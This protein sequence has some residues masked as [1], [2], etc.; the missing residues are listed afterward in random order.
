MDACILIFANNCGGGVFLVAKYFP[1][2]QLRTAWVLFGIVVGMISSVFLYVLPLNNYNG[3][4]AALYMSYFYLG[5]YI[6]ALGINTANTA[7]HTKK[8]SRAAVHTPVHTLIIATIQVTV[9]ALIFIAYCVSNIIAPQFFK[10]NQAPLYPLG[11]GAILGSYVLAI[12]TI[13]AYAAYCYY[14]NRRRDQFDTDKDKRV[15]NDTDFKDLTD[16]QNPHFR[17]CW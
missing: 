12:I 8:V 11:M 15:H 10:S 14:E 17:Y 6:V 5:P 4:L 3:R 13:V 16:K 7:G 9:N 1:Q 2:K